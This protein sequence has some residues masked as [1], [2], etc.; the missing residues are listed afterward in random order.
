MFNN[1]SERRL[2]KCI[3]QV[4]SRVRVTTFVLIVD[5]M[6]TLMMLL[7]H[8]HLAHA[9][10]TLNLEK[11][12]IKNLKLQ[13]QSLTQGKVFLCYCIDNEMLLMSVF[14]NEGHKKPSPVLEIEVAI[15]GF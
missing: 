4:K 3:K 9:V 6:Y 11:V 14:T 10:P 5:R 7:I 1:T 2:V 12:K 15:L 8:C 13:L